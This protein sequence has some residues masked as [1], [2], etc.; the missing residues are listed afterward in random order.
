MKDRKIWVVI[1]FWS[2]EKRIEDILDRKDELA[3]MVDS[4]SRMSLR[5]LWCLFRGRILDCF[6]L[7]RCGFCETCKNSF[8][9]GTCIIIVIIRL[10]IMCNVANFLFFFGLSRAFFVDL[11]LFCLSLFYFT[12]FFLGFEINTRVIWRVVMFSPFFLRLVDFSRVYFLTDFSM[13]I[14]FLFRSGLFLFF[15]R[16]LFQTCIV[17]AIEKNF[18]VLMMMVDFLSCLIVPSVLVTVWTV[19]FIRLRVIVCSFLIIVVIPFRCAIP[20][21]FIPA[22]ITG[23][24]V[25]IL[26]LMM[27]RSFISPRLL[28]LAVTMLTI[29]IS[30]IVWTISSVIHEIAVPIRSC[31]KFIP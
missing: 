28:A 1:L 2:R 30:S 12:T 4:W 24:P 16:A 26:L 29:V 22:Y 21:T 25:F 23:V 5:V 27:M 14:L 18:S 9:W 11:C 19:F 15:L 3:M 17:I 7:F 13:P 8:I 20:R 31:S 6:D 10:L